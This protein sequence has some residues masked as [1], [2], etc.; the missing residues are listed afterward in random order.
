MD[1]QMDGS[2][3]GWMLAKRAYDSEWLTENRPIRQV[4]L[5]KF[6]VATKS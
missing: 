1:V 3:N 4:L 2:K 6:H 5:T